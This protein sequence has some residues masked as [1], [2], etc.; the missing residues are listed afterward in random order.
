MPTVT[1]TVTGSDHAFV[2]VAEDG[3]GTHGTSKTSTG[4]G[5]VSGSGVGVH[6]VSTAGPGVR[7]DAENGVGV[8]GASKTSSGTSGLSETGLGVNGVSTSGD[9]VFG[10][11]ISGRGAVGV[12]ETATGVEGNSTSG[13]GVFGSSKTGIGVHGVGPQR[14]ALFEGDVEV[15]GDLMLSGA[16]VAED[17]DVAGGSEMATPGTVMVLNS[18]AS[19][20]MSTQ[21]YDRRVAGVVSGAGSYRPALLLDRQDGPGVRLP[22]GLMG[23]VFCKV[24]ASAAPVEVGDLLTSAGTKGHAMKATDPTRAFG[25]VVGKALAPLA[26]GRGVIPILICLQ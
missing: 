18:D 24:D 14:A 6:G 19:L 9:G 21:P 8:F 26:T 1:N 10:A 7:G 22:I 20:A 16:D 13:A 5:G 15:T 2:G 12:S 23:K 3:I 17:F 25:A 11:S 4:A